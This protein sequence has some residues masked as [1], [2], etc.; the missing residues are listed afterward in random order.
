MYFEAL[1]FV[2]LHY[3]T[4]IIII[5]FSMAEYVDDSMEQIKSVSDTIVSS[6]ELLPKSYDVVSERRRL[7]EELKYGIYC[8]SALE[9]YIRPLNP[10]VTDHDLLIYS[11]ADMVFTTDGIPVLPLNVSD[12]SDTIDCYTIESYRKYPGFVRIRVLGKMH[13]NWKCKNYEFSHTTSQSIYLSTPQHSTAKKSFEALTETVHGPAIQFQS[14]LTSEPPHDLVLSVWRPQWPE[15]A[16]EWRT[17]RRDNGWPTIETISKVV[18]QGCHVVYVQHRS[19]RD[20]QQQW[21]LSFS[22]AEV[23]LLQSWTKIQQIVY[24]MLRFFAKTEIIQKDCPKEDEVLCPYHLKTLML[25]TCEKMSPEWWNSSSVIVICCKLLR[26]L[27]ECLKKMFCPNYFIRKANLFHE[28]MSS[29]ILKKT[30]SRLREYSN[31]GAL[32]RWFIENYMSPL[33]RT[34]ANDENTMPYFEFRKFMNLENMGFWYSTG[35]LLGDLLTGKLKKSSRDLSIMCLK[36]NVE[37]SRKCIAVMVNFPVSAFCL[38]NFDAALLVLN[39][40]HALECGYILW[41]SRLFADHVKEFC[42]KNDIV[43]CQFQIYPKSY[44]AESS[45]IQFLRALDF[46]TNLTKS[47][48]HAKFQLMSLISKEC[49]KK[50]IECDDSQS[51]GIAHAAMVYLAA[52][53]FASSED[54]IVIDI[55]LAV[56]MD[57]TIDMNHETLNAGCLL[58]IEDVARIVGFCLAWKMF[59]TKIHYNKKQIHLDLRLTPKIFAHYLTVISAKRVFKRIEL[60]HDLPFPVFPL[61]RFI[62]VLATQGSCTP[63]SSGVLFRKVSKRCVSSRMN[64]FTLIAPLSSNPLIM[65]E[66]LIDALTEYALENITSFYRNIRKDCGIQYNTADC[67][68][69]LYLYKSRRYDEVL[70]LCERIL[71][72]PMLQ[73]N[74]EQLILSNVLMLPPLVPLFDGDVQSLL[75][76]Q[77]LCC[78]LSQCH[79]NDD[80]Q[81]FLSAKLKLSTLVKLFGLESFSEESKRLNSVRSP[82]SIKHFNS[83]TSHF[84]ARYLKLRCFVDCNRP[85]FEAMDEFVAMKSDFLLDEIIRSYFLQKLRNFKML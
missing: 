2:L 25:W 65:N 48:G 23:I 77:T 36:R 15:E 24:H 76:F 5:S 13:Y 63:K 44:T 83:L 18:Q 41:D 43:M 47:D 74:F 50:A 14:T 66:K 20:D 67:Y 22:V 72:E 31:S 10:C 58:F 12:L 64:L 35:L 33:T 73:N 80:M 32:C 78:D 1:L 26:M 60:N 55:C 29:V 54:E 59:T 82:F 51:K 62:M 81:Q 46:M 71:G 52:L 7:Q 37:L 45:Q 53:H 11:I 21:R 68:R 6:C 8:G 61:D 70:H 79:V 27:S 40:A 56:L 3:C 57:Q 4:I 28:S 49:L 17:R 34:Y 69:A 16:Q 75:G 9:F 19:C 42:F 39:I 84:L 38:T 85:F 30:E